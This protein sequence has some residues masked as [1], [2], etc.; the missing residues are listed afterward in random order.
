MVLLV[1]AT[2][3][4]GV[5]VAKLRSRTVQEVKMA[6]F[7]MVILTRWIWV[8]SLDERMQEFQGC[9]LTPWAGRVLK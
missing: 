5:G 2:L 6:V 8:C 1:G 4:P 7:T 3:V 9:S